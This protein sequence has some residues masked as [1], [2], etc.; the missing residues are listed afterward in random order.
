MRKKEA[1]Q[2]WDDRHWSQKKLDE[3]TD[4]DWRI[5]REDYSIT[6]KGGKIPNPIRN[7]KE[8]SLPAHI[9]EVIDKCGYKVS[10]SGLPPPPPPPRRLLEMP[11]PPLMSVFGTA[12][13]HS[14]PEAGH[15]NRPTE[16]GHHRRGRN[17][18]R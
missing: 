18:Q 5:F 6:T 12:G 3:M 1:K 11:P 9:L 8:Y 10:P 4:R 17:G 14:H 7:W 2:R 13:T 16:P 15:P